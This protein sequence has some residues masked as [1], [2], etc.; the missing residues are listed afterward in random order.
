MRR[1]NLYNALAAFVLLVSLALL[2]SCKK[3]SNA[4]GLSINCEKYC[5]RIMKCVEEGSTPK[6][7]L[8]YAGG[9]REKCRSSC[10]ELDNKIETTPPKRGIN[11]CID[12]H[13]D[14]EALHTCM[15]NART[16]GP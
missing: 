10:K 3:I 16:K 9:V 5:D 13:S 2:P 15:M 11:D 7:F 8:Q 4:F 6:E 12:K 14:C 1:Q